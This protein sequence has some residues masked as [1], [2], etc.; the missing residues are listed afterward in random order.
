MTRIALTYVAVF[1]WFAVFPARA[2]TECVADAYECAVALVT[3]HDLP[4]AALELQKLLANEPRNLKAGNLLGIVLLEQGKPEAAKAEFQKVVNFEPQFYP[5]LKNLAIAR[6]TL[7][8]YAPAA[9]DFKRVL[10]MKPDDP[11]ASLYLGELSYRSGDSA[12]ALLNFRKSG[13]AVLSIPAFSVHYADCLLKSDKTNE[14]ISV[15]DQL[16]ESAG[17]AQ[18]AAGVLLFRAKDFPA[19]ARSFH[20]AQKSYSDPCAAGYNEGLSNLRS[21]ANEA[22]VEVVNRILPACQDK[23]EL[24]NLEAAAYRKLNQVQPAYNA[25]KK[26]AELSPYNEQNYIDLSDLCIDYNNYEL[27]ADIIDLGLKKIPDSQRL[28]LHKGIMEA[29]RGNLSKAESNF[30]FAADIAPDANLPKAALSLTWMAMGQVP[31]AV[32]TLRAADKKNGADFTIPFLLAQA[33]I[34][35]GIAAGSSEE[36]EAIAAFEKAV[37]LNPQYAPARAELGKLFL[38]KGEEARGI[39]ELEKALALDPK[40]RTAAYQLAQVYRKKGNQHRAA[41]LNARVR[42][43]NADDRDQDLKRAM[44]SIVRQTARNESERARPDG[45]SELL[46]VAR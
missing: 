12:Q 6:F 38:R 46:H 27:G 1:C 4:A 40:E 45:S 3:R 25:L 21:D 35:Q 41:E 30:Q 31:K 34:R 18:F 10:A 9:A 7:G 28:Y 36:R 2:Q 37:A 20:R 32:E 23:S 14:A 26:A 24:L 44:I 19:A 16:N 39:A 29:M 43:L 13:A 11:I 17:E 15:L 42:S 22:V 8:E 33:L 5:A